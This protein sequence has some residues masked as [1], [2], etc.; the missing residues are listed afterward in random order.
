MTTID[1]GA[2]LDTQHMIPDIDLD[3]F[4]TSRSTAKARA[5]KDQI[6]RVLFTATFVVATIPLIS[7]LW[8]TVAN[9]AKRLNVGFLTHNMTGVIGGNPTAVGGY[10]GVLHAILGT[11][12]ITLGAMVISIP[13]GV[14]CAVYLIEYAKDGRLAKT[15]RLLVD[16]MSGIPSIVA[17]LFAL[18]LFAIVCGP[19]T[20]NGFEGSVALALLMLPTVCKSSEEMLR[21][22]PNELREASLALGVTKQRTITKVVLRTALPGIVS[23]SI[24][25][26]AR[27]IGETAPLLMTAGYIVSTNVNLFSGQMTTLPVYVYQ[28]YSKLTA[29]CPPNAGAS[30]VT[31]IPMERAWSAA[32]VLIVIVLVLNLIG[33][34]VA[35]I[36]SVST[37]R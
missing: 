13:I 9:G 23:G 35:K 1:H 10:G 34:I 28:E 4:K 14:M 8:T 21:I 5:R 22:V 12:E 20:F 27:V 33:R 37:E 32:L 3:A 11:L 29:N 25:A 15:I 31:T 6:M 18:S 16:V 36:C 17:G 7:L 30:C 19:G 24:L 26:V 2:L